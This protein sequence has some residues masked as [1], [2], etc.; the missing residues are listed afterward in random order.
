M[1]LCVYIHTYVYTH[2][3]RAGDNLSITSQVPAWRVHFYSDVSHRKKKSLERRYCIRSSKWNQRNQPRQAPWDTKKG[4]QWHKG[5][6]LEKIGSVPTTELKGSKRIFSATFKGKRPQVS[7]PINFKMKSIP[8]P[9]G[10]PKPIPASGHAEKD[11]ERQK[12][13]QVDGCRRGW[14][15]PEW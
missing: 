1:Q 4:K 14:A 5:T 7:E 2:I 11:T 12:W 6:E 8:K 10:L 3:Q 15:S 13:Q 9:M